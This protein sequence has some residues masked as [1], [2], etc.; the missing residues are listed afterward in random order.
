LLLVVAPIL[1]LWH[2]RA[3]DPLTPPNVIVLVTDDQGYGDLGF[4]EN[5]VLRTP[6][7]DQLARESARFTR[8]YVSPVC[9]PT[10]ASLLTGRYHYRTGVVD[11]YIGRSLMHPDETTLAEVLGEA[12]YRTGIFGKWHLGDNYPMRPID[13]GF[14]E[15]LVHKGGGIGQPS[16]PPDGRSYFNPVLQHNGVAVR[17]QG[18][19]S[20]VYTDAALG[21]IE[22]NRA[23]PFLVWL[24][25]NAPHT[26][27]EVPEDYE[28]RYREM[29]LAAS[30]FPDRGRSIAPAYSE[31]T[32]A[33]IYGMVENID[34]NVGRLLD[35]LERLD[36]TSRT[37]VIF[38]TDN[39]P[40]QPRYNSGFRGLK[41]T[42]YEGGIRVPFFIRWPGHVAAGRSIDRI[43]AHIDV[44]PTLLEICRVKAPAVL[45][46]DGVSLWPL[47]QGADGDWP[48]RTL[49]LQWHRGDIPSSGRAF[50]AV[51]QTYKL[52]Q[53]DGTGEGPWTPTRS[54][55][56]F[57]LVD[58]AFEMTDRAAAE[59][60]VS[61]D[62][63]RAYERWFADV[64]AQRDYRAPS[65]IHLGTA[66][67][68]PTV[69]T[70]QDWRGPDA[71]W[72]PRSRGFWEVDVREAGA[73]TVTIYFA[74]SRENR[75]ARVKIGEV[76]A[77]ISAAAGATALTF[78]N[79]QLDT[80]P[81]RL[82]AWLDMGE[83]SVGPD[84][85]TVTRR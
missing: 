27:L 61:A 18:Y 60:G 38:L 24:A 78:E 3:E 80:G 77:E 81:S 11:T 35:Q 2:L 34:D 45:R 69:L 29:N 51:T 57:H 10:R 82:E 59:P 76:S 64:T 74:A 53:A 84:Y 30:R 73:H 72:A 49:F 58:D 17:K 47:L 68:N 56:L 46:M 71:G 31:E 54:P 43:A 39:G 23:R 67:E 7:L 63:Q 14:D 25:F 12:G 85:V 15:A 55:E 16:D 22:A 70:R 41:G 26:P 37:V 65:R 40:Q 52:V 9:S 33:K 4:H 75:R 42:V 21:F 32:T 28:R 83:T 62:L 36:L 48:E 19:C 66:H 1:L 5:P 44:M 8:F 13:Q 79:L 6:R 20:D 50:A